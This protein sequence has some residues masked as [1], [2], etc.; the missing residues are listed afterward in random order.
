[1]LGE[2]SGL[3]L[4]S[5]RKVDDYKAFHMLNSKR[6]A[7]IRYP[8]ALLYVVSQGVGLGTNGE[9]LFVKQS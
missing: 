9:A 8:F 3:N 2:K 4:F 5:Y 7:I 1:M 6:S